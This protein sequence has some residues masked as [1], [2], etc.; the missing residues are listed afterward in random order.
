MKTLNNFPVEKK[1]VLLRVDLN[2]PTKNGIVID[3]TKFQ[4]I[5]STVS[6][7]SLKKNKIFLLSHFGRP[8]K[9]NNK[10]FSLKF[11]KKNLAESLSVK[12]I[13]FVSKCY[14]SIIDQQKNIYA[15]R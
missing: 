3:K 7:L 1:N 4:I 5:K 6:I 15:A 11:L 13:Y 12:K 10:K 8:N 14:G 9:K 2:V